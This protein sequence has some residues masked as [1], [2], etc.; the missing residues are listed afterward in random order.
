MRRNLLVTT[1]LAALLC[2]VSA[3]AFATEY[4][5]VVSSTP[6]LGQAPVAQ[7][8]CNDEQV[9]VA[10]RTS[11]GGAI[12]GALVG[13]AIG[14]AV[15]G[16]MG[17]AAATGLGVVAG[18]AIGDSAER[19]NAQAATS[20][21]QR[22]R[23]VTQYED[24]LI[25]YDVVYDYAGTQRTVRLGQD[26]G[27]PGSRIALEVNVAGAVSTA[28][29]AGSRIGTPVPSRGSAPYE[30]SEPIRSDDGYAAPAPRTYYYDPYYAPAPAYY[31]PAPA[32]YGGPYFGPSIWIG[33]SWHYGGHRR[34]H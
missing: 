23:T 9:R 5:T 21:V 24:R 7:R 31:V 3:A 13:G 4:G 15:G 33:G 25:G 18:A 1:P 14:N 34:W 26:P 32:Y 12:V 22:C 20:T 10:P 11:G 19:E 29:R 27:A 2:T 16:G 8:V 28:P 6:V 17:R 30:Y